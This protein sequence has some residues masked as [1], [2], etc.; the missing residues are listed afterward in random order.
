MVLN[1]TSGPVEYD[2]SRPGHVIN[3]S[4]VV[5]P[6]QMQ[7]LDEEPDILAVLPGGDWCA[8]IGEECVPLVAFVVLDD[9]SVFGVVLGEN[10]LVDLAQGNAEDNPNFV[11]YARGATQREG[12]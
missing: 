10:G 4:D 3:T 9:A 8:V 5:E 7:Y 6:P 2:R 11:R 1:T 12:E